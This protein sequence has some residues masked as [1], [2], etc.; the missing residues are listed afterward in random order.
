MLTRRRFKH[1]VSFQDRLALFAKEARDKALQMPAGQG[2][3]G[4]AAKG[5]SGRD[6]IPSRRVG[7][8]AGIAVS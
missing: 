5:A 4:H 3:G 8:F 1:A 2:A 7:Q 6:R